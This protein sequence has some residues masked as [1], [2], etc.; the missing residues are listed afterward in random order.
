M[1][2]I[3]LP[4]LHTAPI[5]PPASPLEMYGQ[6][7]G[8]Q[9]AQLEQQQRQQA[10]QTGQLQQQGAQLELNQAQQAQK[11]Q[12]T[13]RAAMQ[14]PENQGKTIG[15]IAD[16]LAHQGAITPQGWQAMKKADVDQ[17]TALAGLDEKN[18]ANAAA[19]HKQ[20]QDLYN[21]AMNMTPEQLAQNWPAITEAYNAIPGN[22]KVPLNPQQP[23]T[24]EQ[25][26]Q[27]GPMLAMHGA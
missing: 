11:D 26:Q 14:S 6:M 21:N 22:Q 3:P 13:F 10:M 5:Q 16:T 2:T 17:R 23:M 25:L 1:A 4:A 9:N 12:Q 18:L 15:D 7:M 8:I 19:A 27:F 20:S 24:K